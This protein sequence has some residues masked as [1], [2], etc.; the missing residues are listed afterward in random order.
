[1]D[2]RRATNRSPT[3]SCR[4][5]VEKIAILFYTCLV[6]TLINYPSVPMSKFSAKTLLWVLGLEEGTAT[7]L[8]FYVTLYSKLET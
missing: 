5:C 3:R 6:D 4:I 2:E 7:V 8:N 1:M